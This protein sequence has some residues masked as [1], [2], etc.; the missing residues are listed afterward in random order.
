MSKLTEIRAEI[1][2]SADPKRA[3]ALMRFFKTGVGQYGE[4]DKFLGIT[5][6]TT[7]AIVKKYKDLSL[8]DTQKF[9]KSKWHEE[10]MIALL[11][12]L[13]KFQKADSKLQ[14]T[15]F[16]IYLNNTKYINNW[17]LVDVTCRDIVG[18]YLDK[19]D[20]KILYKLAT[21]KS[22]WE[23][24]IS[25]IST[26]YYIAQSDFNDT[27]KI[28]KILLSDKHDLIHKAVGWVLREVGKKDITLLKKFLK[29]NYENI[30]RT[31]LR[32][33]IERFPDLERKKYLK[34]EID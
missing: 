33:S 4:G 28:S 10:R 17:D 13:E 21:S 18:A 27:L 14:K 3:K 2:G 6:P 31:A 29:E 22:L 9:L 12:L 20:R 34:G 32:Y 24:R 1:K 16:E 25:I 23:R 8:P 26:F 30:P 5:L 19:K 15:I 7:R 11:I